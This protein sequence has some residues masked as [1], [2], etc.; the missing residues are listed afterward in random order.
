MIRQKQFKEIKLNA[1]KTTVVILFCAVLTL[2]A[3]PYE[4]AKF[5]VGSAAI[6]DFAICEEKDRLLLAHADGTIA[7]KKLSTGETSTKFKAHEASIFSIDISKD[8]TLALTAADDSTMSVWNLSD[9]SLITSVTLEKNE[10]KAVFLAQDSL[11]Y[12]PTTGI[13]SAI[14]SDETP[15]ITPGVR[16][17]A[18][19]ISPDRSLI[20]RDHML[21]SVSTG[22][23][24]IAG[25]SSFVTELAGAISPD[26]KYFALGSNESKVMILSAET[27]EV[28]ATLERAGLALIK[29]LA[30]S[31]DSK[32]LLIGSSGGYAGLWDFLND[33][34]SF[35]DKYDGWITELAV[36]KDSISYYSLHGGK[37]I[38][39]WQTIG[40]GLTLYGKPVVTSAYPA[41]GVSFNLD[42]TQILYSQGDTTFVAN[43]ET[44]AI[45]NRIDTVADKLVMIPGS[46]H[47][48]LHK[49]N[50]FALIDTTNDSLILQSPVYDNGRY[51]VSVDSIG[52]SPDGTHAAMVYNKWDMWNTKAAGVT[53]HYINLQSGE[54]LDSQELDLHADVTMAISHDGN[55]LATTIGDTAVTFWKLPELVKESQVLVMEASSLQSPFWSKDDAKLYL[56]LSNNSL[57]RIDVAA[58]MLDIVD[59]IDKTG[60]L[61]PCFS[62]DRGRLFLPSTTRVINVYT[63]KLS[64]QGS[65]EVPYMIRDMQCS[66]DGRLLGVLTD[67]RF[68]LYDTHTLQ[69][70]V[71]YEIDTYT[72]FKFW[73]SPTANTLMMQDGDF[74]ALWDISQYVPITHVMQTNSSPQLVLKGNTL[75][76]DLKETKGKAISFSLF[77]PQGR[78]VQKIVNRASAQTLK[79][80]NDIATGMYLYSITVDKQVMQNGTMHIR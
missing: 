31:S 14:Y 64:L 46:S 47:L 38:R 41:K 25:K 50:S 12:A 15:T 1:Y 80:E 43:A 76:L 63:E 61:V 42:G 35:T 71:S 5:L 33:D 16:N 28:V 34:N 22:E 36:S 3:L 75:T 19:A 65:I 62:A 72:S 56:L 70:R 52:F 11:I 37:E 40:S 23:L 7:I 51:K 77:T 29:S 48:F 9:N 24:V 6:N 54:M 44:G 79:L 66:H 21:F 69:E 30:F 74:T 49:K 53:L 13:V 17:G 39:K 8:G 67:T 58:N 18:F 2:F 68:A 73:L 59:T 27:G 4:S 26:N 60:A 45:E 10:T 32:K 57:A 55:T 78:L 20:Q